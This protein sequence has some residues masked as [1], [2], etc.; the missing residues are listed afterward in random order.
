MEDRS[1]QILAVNILFFVLSWVAISLRVYVRAGM[2]KSFGMDDW[3]M[4]VTVLLFT[5]FLSCQLGGVL[6]GAGR[7]IR[8]LE[9]QNAEKALRFWYLAELF[10]VLSNCMLKIALG[11]FLL[12]VASKKAHIWIIRLLMLGTIVFGTSYFF[13][14]LF[15][16]S[17]ISQ[18]WTASPSSPK[19]MDP[20]IITSTTYVAS[21][22]TAFA[23]WTFGILP[24]FIVWDLKMARKAKFMVAG[25]LAF[26]A[27]GSTAT[28][29]R[30]PSIHGLDE[31]SDF[32]WST[33]DVTIWSTVEPGIGI[34]AGCIVT[35]RPLLQVIRWKTGLS[36]SRPASLP[37][38]RP[39]EAR[40]RQSRFGYHRSYGPEE[41]RPDNAWT[42]T[43]ATGPQRNWRDRSNSEERMVGG[44]I[45]KEVVFEYS[46]EVSGGV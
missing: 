15:Q 28:I 17:P 22:I 21:G 26:A 46:A 24:F 37:L 12:R 18:F 38:E 8:D 41:L 39:G 16:C 6:H 5:A 20:K 35:L 33:V 13:L 27:I 30:I 43:T 29:I 2:L 31:T 14:M 36:S 19:C 1:H 7:H 45:N 44:G 9:P 23:D 25:I 34:I 42:I 32:L 3:A 11:I 10:Y 40:K 4:V